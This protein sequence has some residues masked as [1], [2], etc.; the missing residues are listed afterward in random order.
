MAREPIF[1]KTLDEPGLS[2]IKRYESLGGYAS[3]KKALKRMDRQG[4]KQELDDAFLR[5]RGGAGFPI[6]RK[7]AFMPEGAMDKF[8]CCNCDESE[9]GAFKDRELVHKNPH[10]LF[11]GM[12]ILSYAIQA[13][14]AFVYIRGEY[15]EEAEILMRALDQVHRA[16]Y[17]GEN[18][19][20]TGMNL[21]L[22]VH[23][24]AGAYVCG[25]E[26]ALMDSLEGKRGNPRLKPP[27]PANAGLYQG[28][29]E[30]NN[31]ET[32]SNIPHIIANGGKWYA[33]YGREKS[34]GTKM[35][36]ISGN[37]KRPGNWEIELGSVTGRD[38][39]YGHAGGPHPGKRVKLWFP[40][41]TSGHALTEK[42]LDAPYDYE[43]MA[44]VGSAMGSA[45][46][47]VMDETNDA[48]DV[49]HRV[50]G[51]YRHESCGKC[52]PCRE[53]TNWTELILGRILGG[54]GT[55]EDME[56][57]RALQDEILGQCLC[58]LGDSMAMSVK[59]IIERCPDDF[60][61]M[62]IDEGAVGADVRTGAARG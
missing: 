55:T 4:V 41:G 33:E 2:D 23:R 20:G 60:A 17:A 13:S 52:S 11:E 6:G 36:S 48:V 61:G 40:G 31:V 24:G 58:P 3:L 21:K 37:V 39:I 7:A 19:L 8:L 1:M 49:A 22:T 25:D 12:I 47:I 34:R 56:T 15:V 43:G 59:S 5:G 16:G 45:S 10:Q 51:F 53:G 26:T 50:A 18:I 29:T 57:L 32:I 46:I 30:I 42:E 35:V 27:F 44:A 9:P 14:H 54:H 28:P 38:L 62:L